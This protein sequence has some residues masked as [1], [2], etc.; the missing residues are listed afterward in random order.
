RGE[1]YWLYQQVQHNVD[2]MTGP[3]RNTALEGFDIVLQPGWNLIGSPYPSGVPIQLEQEYFWGPITYDGSKWVTSITT[4]LAP[5]GGY[6]V[7]NRNQSASETVTL[8]AAPGGGL[9]KDLLAKAEETPPDGWLLQLEVVGR[10]YGDGLNSIGRLE[11]A[12]EQLDYFDNPEPPYVAGFISLAMERPDWGANMPLM[13]SDIRSLEENDGV[14]DMDLHVKG[15]QGPITLSYELEGDLPPGNRIVLLDVLTREVHDLLATGEPLTITDYRERFP[16]HLN[17]IAGSA[18][19]VAYTTEEILASLPS[20][21]A[22]AQN[23]PN[24]FN[25]FTH[26]R[27]SLFRP[28][29]VTLKIFNLLG[30]EVVTLVDG[31]QDLGHY[32]VLWNGRDRFGIPVASGV[33]FAAYMAE[34]RIYTRKMVMMK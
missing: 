19:Y 18:D 24:P 14:W 27:Y 10:T 5:W 33:Y 1:G 11:G 6:A 31:W 34:G 8:N 23:Y 7:Y 17:V 2:L 26:L 13:T 16:Y 9:G 3:G 22:L 21:F 20:D 12:S 28:A 30:R 29:K 32:E 4:E 15:E 25:P